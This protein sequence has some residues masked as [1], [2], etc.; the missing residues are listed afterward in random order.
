MIWR[1]IAGDP[2]LWSKHPLVLKKMHFKNLDCVMG[3]GQFST[4]ER[5]FASDCLLTNKVLDFVRNHPIK[6]LE[7]GSSDPN[8]NSKTF[9]ETLITL[10][11]VELCRGV[12]DKRLMSALF[13][14]MMEGTKMKKFSLGMQCPDHLDPKILAASLNKIEEVTID[15]TR[16]SHLHVA[17][18]F[19]MMNKEASNIKK[20]SWH[21]FSEQLDSLSPVTFSQPLSKLNSCSLFY[22]D[23][24]NNDSLKP[25]IVE[26]F[27]IC[28]IKTNLKELRL[29]FTDLTFVDP[30]IFTTVVSS[31]EKVSLQ[32]SVLSLPQKEKMFEGL[33]SGKSKM[34][35][36]NLS[37]VNISGVHPDTLAEGINN[38][39]QVKIRSTDLTSEQAEKLL[40]QCM[41]KSSLKKLDIGG[42][43]DIYLVKNIR[44]IVEAVKSKIVHFTFC[45]CFMVLS[46]APFHTCREC[47]YV[48]C[49]TCNYCFRCNVKNYDRDF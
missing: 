22:L 16:L 34:K 8:I 14:K 42:N 26:L 12:L 41:K 19:S 39:Q 32:N 11:T 6:H 23:D 40:L 13:N 37:N 38:L 3:L 15:F 27:K 35:V 31:I 36:L 18:I 1:K 21:G 47:K 44:N 33:A 48:F 30:I 7:L 45:G 29:A 25:K 43:R 24:T 20:F 2:L 4:L 28:S 10:E 9:S 17:K 49:F 5:L 46:Q